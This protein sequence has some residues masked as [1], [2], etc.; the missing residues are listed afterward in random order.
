VSFISQALFPT[1][2]E[3]FT[4]SPAYNWAVV[5]VIFLVII[6][7]FFFQ[8]MWA[9]LVYKGSNP[10]ASL[11]SA[12]TWTRRVGGRGQLGFVFLLFTHE[13]I[14]ILL[15]LIFRTV[16]TFSSDLG[17]FDVAAFSLP[18]PMVS[19]LILI[20]FEI[21]FFIILILYQVAQIPRKAPIPLKQ[22]PD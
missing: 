8:R 20:G 7:A 11:R 19:F 2:A 22:T 16:P 1:F 17:P 15:I 12:L 3:D 18:L 21:G 9:M 14:Q 13:L 4:S 6:M 10:D 5:S